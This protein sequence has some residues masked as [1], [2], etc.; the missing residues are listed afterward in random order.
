[1]VMDVAG[2]YLPPESGERISF[3]I[4]LLLGY[5]VFLIMVSETLPATGT[6]LI[7]RKFNCATPFFRTMSLELTL[8]LLL[9]ELLMSSILTLS[10]IAVSNVVKI[11][12]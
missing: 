7:G 11:N 2:F 9:A 8:I 10:L 5:S 4:T 3:K 1:M 12:Q 6:P